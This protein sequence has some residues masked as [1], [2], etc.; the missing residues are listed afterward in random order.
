MDDRKEDYK[1]VPYPVDR[2]IVVDSG[3]LAARRH[4]IHAL[5][6]ID[7]TDARRHIRDHR[8]GTGRSLSFTAFLVCCLA[9]AIEA[10]PGVCAYKARSIRGRRLVI[11]DDV[12]VAV[13]IETQRDRVAVPYIIRGANRKTLLQVNDEIRAVQADPGR[14]A[15]WK[16]MAVRAGKLPRFARDIFYRFMIGNPH[17]FKRYSGT[18]VVT[19][20]GMFARGGGWAIGFLPMHTLGLTVGGIVRR[21]VLVEDKIANREYLPVTISF[22]HDVVDGAPAARFVDHFGR[23]VEEAACLNDVL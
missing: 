11:F 4:I 1:T 18:V 21:P 7:V 9:R 8:A 15:A 13:M 17:R 19:A 14:S 6:E 5:I 23:L 10:H 20:V 3:R 22:D 12:D 2:E 16:G